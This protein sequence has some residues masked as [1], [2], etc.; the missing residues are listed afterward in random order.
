MSDENGDL[1]L[2]DDLPA[3][4]GEDKFHHITLLHSVLFFSI[5]VNSEK[6]IRDAL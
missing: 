4:G 3:T 5:K 1:R 6:K 2:L